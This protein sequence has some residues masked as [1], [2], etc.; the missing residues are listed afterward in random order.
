MTIFSDMVVPRSAIHWTGIFV[1]MILSG[2]A[3]AEAGP[4]LSP[5]QEEALHAMA[6]DAAFTWPEMSAAQARALHAKAE[7][8][9]DAY[10]RYHLPHGLSADVW[11]HDYDRKSVYR[12]E[13]LGDS[14][15]WTGHYLA[16]LAMRYHLE[17]GPELRQR[18]LGVLD[19][20]DLLIAVSGRRG[21]IARYA[22][23]ATD[24]GYQGYYSVY[25]RGEDPERPGLGLRAYRGVPPYEDLVWLGYS[26][27]D[28]YDGTQYGL[29][30]TLAYIDDDEIRG[31]ITTIVSAVADRLIA[32]DWDILDGKGN[33]TRGNDFFKTAWMRLILSACPG[34]YAHLEEPYA[35]LCKKL[36]ERG[37]RV[38][39]IRYGEYFANNLNFIRMFTL[40]VLEQAPDR[41]EAFLAAMRRMHEA[42][43]PH[44]NAHFAAIYVLATGDKE[45][46]KARA[47]IQGLLI[48]FPDP[49]KFGRA[50]NLRGAPGIEQENDDYTKYAQLPRERVPTD[51]MWQRSPCVSHGSWD[52]P[53]EFPGIDLFLPYWMG[54]VAGIIPEP[55]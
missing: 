52:L 44:L 5:Q 49:P 25:G 7:A 48:D 19:K 51:F 21:Y 11:W 29:A 47:A 37:G 16:A 14:A 32:D 17:P 10:H 46:P 28:I 24:A 54:R 45:N 13:G 18:I 39:D 1:F 22:G 31:R 41:K 9:L 50:V 55:K 4:G 27:R 43:A 6:R 42:V 35:D 23:P 8:Y 33:R 2:I 12:L 38:Y 3:I 30:A 53:F 40:C 26:S 15:T 20:F 34:Q 36:S